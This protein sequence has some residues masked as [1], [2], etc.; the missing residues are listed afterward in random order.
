M[1]FDNRLFLVEVT[2]AQLL[3]I[4]RVGSSG[5]HGIHQIAG[6]TYH[7]D[8]DSERTDDLDGDGAREAWENDRLCKATVGGN[9]VDPT[10]TYRLV[11]TDFLFEGGDHM[12]WPFRDTRIV[13][14]GEPLFDQ[15]VRFTTS[16]N[17]CWGAVSPTP[18]P[19]APRIERGPC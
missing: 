6:G 11:T 12:A 16:Q 18:E 7:F 13:V 2:G 5:A 8:P 15:L 9:P 4:L 14:E 10:Q 19:T 3:D 1:P 17:T